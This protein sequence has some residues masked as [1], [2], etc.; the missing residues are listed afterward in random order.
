M[1]NRFFTPW[2]A[3]YNYSYITKNHNIKKKKTAKTSFKIGLGS[4]EAVSRKK[5]K[6]SDRFV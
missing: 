2:G 6:G 4:F 5:L 3:N 1:L